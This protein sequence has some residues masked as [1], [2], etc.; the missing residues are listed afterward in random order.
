M[1]KELMISMLSAGNNGQQILEI[2][3]SF[4]AQ[5]EAVT[6]SN[7]PTLETIEF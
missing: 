3:D 4:T 1:S 6:N 2:L 7:Q 5:D